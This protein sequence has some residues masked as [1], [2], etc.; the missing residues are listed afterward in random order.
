M[1]EICRLR[2]TLDDGYSLS[3]FIYIYT[4]Y[5]YM[6]ILAADLIID[7]GLHTLVGA[8]FLSNLFYIK[9]LEYF[10]TIH[11]DFRTNGLFQ[12]FFS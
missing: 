2:A 6:I 7:R 3:I 9:T 1:N 10:F 8:G 11:P 12:E 5:T 4:Y